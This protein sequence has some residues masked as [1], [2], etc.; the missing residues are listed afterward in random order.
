METYEGRSHSILSTGHSSLG[1]E[2]VAGG[3][4]TTGQHVQLRLLKLTP[5]HYQ[6]LLVDDVRLLVP[7]QR[8]HIG[9]NLVAQIIKRFHQTA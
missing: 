9:T 2:N 6:C 3:N 8:A 4:V 5:R 1:V 7:V